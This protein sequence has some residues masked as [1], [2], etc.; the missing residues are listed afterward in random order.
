M[1]VGYVVILE[2]SPQMRQLANTKICYYTFVNYLTKQICL[3]IKKKKKRKLHTTK[4]D[5]TTQYNAEFIFYS[6]T[7]IA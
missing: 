6:H 4:N 7:S 5:I 1:N 2:Y 3:L